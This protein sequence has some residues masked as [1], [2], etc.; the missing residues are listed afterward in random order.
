ML[1]LYACH[2]CRGVI[3]R[4]KVRTHEDGTVYGELEEKPLTV[5]SKDDNCWRQVDVGG[6]KRWACLPMLMAAGLNTGHAAR[7]ADLIV[8]VTRDL[9]F[10]PN[11]NAKLSFIVQLFI[12]VCLRVRACVL[13]DCY[14]PMP[15]SPRQSPH[16]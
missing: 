1:I 3:W 12:R 2:V 4:G 7:K 14:P 13:S 11:D 10:R 15:D 8:L 16:I 6:T 9:T 5:L